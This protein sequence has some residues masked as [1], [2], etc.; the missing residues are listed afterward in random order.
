MRWNQ[1]LLQVAEILL[2][3]LLQ[4]Y[5]HARGKNA[6]PACRIRVPLSYILFN[7]AAHAMLYLSM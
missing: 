3:V 2:L 5:H 4:I 1:I 7:T 6:L